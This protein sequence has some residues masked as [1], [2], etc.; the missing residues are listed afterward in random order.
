MPLQLGMKTWSSNGRDRIASQSK[1][2]DF[3]EVMVEPDID[4]HYLKEIKTKW[5]VHC[6]HMHFGF[7]PANRDRWER[8][9][10]VLEKAQKAA[11][12]LKADKIIVH[13][14]Y[15]ENKTL[16]KNGLK[17]ALDFFKNIKD[18]RILLENSSHVF[19]GKDKKPVPV[20]ATPGDAEAILKK[21]GYGFCLDVAHAWVSAHCLGKDPKDAIKDFLKLKPAYFHVLDSTSL[22]K[23]TH[24][25]L[26][27]GMLDIAFFRDAIKKYNQNAMIALETPYD[28]KKNKKE[29]AFMKG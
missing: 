3:T 7:N 22:E 14:G 23:D 13:F 26:G 25:N 8:S 18:K 12:F 11:T 28:L 6:G 4:Y 9:R 10:H 27:E 21:T 17:N 24:T 15:I 19:F 1:I 2:G 5:T 29:I 20:M 16:A